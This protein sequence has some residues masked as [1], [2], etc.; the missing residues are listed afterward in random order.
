MNLNRRLKT[1]CEFWCTFKS[2]ITELVGGAVGPEP[3]LVNVYGVQE[4]IPKN[5]FRQSM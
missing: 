4:S 3:V 5:R 1:V 2:S